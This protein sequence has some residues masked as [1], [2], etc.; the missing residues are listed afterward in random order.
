MIEFRC[1]V[2]D[3]YHELI[4]VVA[5]EL[6]ARVRYFRGSMNVLYIMR[7]GEFLGHV[8]VSG[9]DVK[10]LRKAVLEVLNAN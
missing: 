7:A 1:L 8:W 6:A 3:D 2:T 4:E 5:S 10:S 9:K